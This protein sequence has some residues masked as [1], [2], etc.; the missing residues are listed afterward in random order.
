MNVLICILFFIC[1]IYILIRHKLADRCRNLMLKNLMF[2]FIITT[3]VRRLDFP[4]QSD[5]RLTNV[6]QF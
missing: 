3:F 2:I 6:S 1:I 4:K 5:L